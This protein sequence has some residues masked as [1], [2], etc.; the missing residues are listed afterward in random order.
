[1]SL[2]IEGPSSHFFTPE[3]VAY[4]AVE[5]SLAGS[6]E[7]FFIAKRGEGGLI[8]EVESH[9]YG[10]DD[11]VPAI[12][13]RA[14]PGD[15]LIHNHPGGNLLPSEADMG[16]A[17]AMG[18]EGIGFYI[19][20]DACSRCRVVVKAHDPKKKVLLREK[21]VIE[22]LAPRSALAHIVDDYEDRPQQRTMS[23]AIARAFNEDGIAVI[24]AGTGT[25]KSFAYLVPS[26]LYAIGNDDRVVISTN[27]INLQEQLLHKDI[28]MLRAAIGEEFEVEIVKGRS[29]YVCK[30]KASFAADSAPSLI[31]DEFAKELREVLDWAGKSAV[32]DRGELPVAP[33]PEVWERIGSEAD[34]CLRVKCP[35]YAECFFY[36]SR[37]RAARVKLLIVNHSL[38]MSDLSVRRQSNNYSSAVVL[39]PYKRLIIDEAHHLEEVATKNLSQ[40]ITRVGV[41][42]LFGRMYRKDS[43]GRGVFTAVQ[44]ALELLVTRRLMQADDPRIQRLLFDLIPRVADVRDSLDFMIGDFGNHFMRVA[45]IDAIK[46][47][48]EQR[49]RITD[50]FKQHPLWQAECETLLQAMAQ[51]ILQFVELNRTVLATLSDLEEKAELIIQNSRLEWSALIGRLDGLRKSIVSFLEADDTVCRWVELA[52]PRQPASRDVVVRI[53]LAPVDVRELLRTSLHDRMKTEIMTSATLTVDKTFH[54]FEERTGVPKSAGVEEPQRDEEGL[55][56]RQRETVEPRPVHMHALPTPFDYRNQVFFGVPTDLPD[57]REAGFDEEL[58]NLINGSVAIT[59]GRA[60]IL[61]TSFGQL[62]RVADLCE[63]TIRKLGIDVLRQGGD[64]RDLLLRRFR[65]DETSVL[66]ATSSFWEGV[67]VKGR[68]LELLILAKLPFAVPSDPIQEAQFEYMQKQGR[69]PF[70]NLVV[71]RAV[72]R[73]KQGFGRLIR[74]RTDRGAVIIADK[75][76]T[77][78]R[79]GRRFLHSLP[80]VQVR[81][82]TSRDLM[83]DMDDFFSARSPQ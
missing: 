68:A 33:R 17:S 27:T 73:F 15:V 11:C 67:D 43:G 74:S 19:I 5:I 16:I 31:E 14:K 51:E 32:G 66:F 83:R 35:F 60:F 4:C 71:P 36:N 30:R 12:T 82:A 48:E 50:G 24:E 56:V 44:E 2:P 59:G 39:P 62:R 46:P 25:G 10:T 20:D 64:N 22:A 21:D 52:A 9:A 45:G 41:R 54:F 18:N 80:D 49:I 6:V 13:A 3:A 53:C 7:V 40:V 1:M 47:R 37:R 72:I 29:N 42:Q 70:D 77:Q 26:L 57:P 63:P 79:Y 8:E 55:P 78:M 28:P 69:D 34:N 58:A 65:E 38:L 75:R 81:K 23:E 61:F 76:I